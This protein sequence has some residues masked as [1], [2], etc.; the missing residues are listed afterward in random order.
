MSLSPGVVSPLTQGCRLII[1]TL[2]VLIT[3]PLASIVKEMDNCTEGPLKTTSEVAKSKCL[4]WLF[5]QL[6]LAFF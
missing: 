1:F 5:L 6:S 4:C 2:P 3:D